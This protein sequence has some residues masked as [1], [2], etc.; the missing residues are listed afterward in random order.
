MTKTR[1]V[2]VLFRRQEYSNSSEM[3]FL[4]WK[5]SFLEEGVNYS[6]TRGLRTGKFENLSRLG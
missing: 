4:P 6:V 1:S 3:K 2:K 5:Q